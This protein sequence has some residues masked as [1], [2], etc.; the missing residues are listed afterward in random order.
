VK[1][2]RIAA[3]LGKKRWTLI[4]GFIK[5][6]TEAEFEELVNEKGGLSIAINKLDAINKFRS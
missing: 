2:N 4:G 6:L 1:T 5:E 3:P